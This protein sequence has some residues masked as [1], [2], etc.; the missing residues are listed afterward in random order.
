MLNPPLL[1]D[2]YDLR[3]LGIPTGPHFSTLLDEVRDAQLENH[4]H[5]KP[6]ALAWVQQRWRQL[7]PHE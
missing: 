4:V 6:T 3:Q 5:D 1:I 2:G 7:C